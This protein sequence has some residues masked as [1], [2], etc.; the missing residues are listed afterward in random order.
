M[1]KLAYNITKVRYKLLHTILLPMKI[2]L[3]LKW[4]FSVSRFW[5]NFELDIAAIGARSGCYRQTQKYLKQFR[6]FISAITISGRDHDKILN[7][8][9]IQKPI[10]SFLSVMNLIAEESTRKTI[11]IEK[12][13]IENFGEWLRKSMQAKLASIQ[14]LMWRVWYHRSILES[15]LLHGLSSQPFACNFLNPYP[16]PIMRSF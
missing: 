14:I 1:Q 6:N 11:R 2:S 4:Y 8:G 13:T 5:S 16:I 9:K 15:T 3:W 12:L 10:Q 7:G